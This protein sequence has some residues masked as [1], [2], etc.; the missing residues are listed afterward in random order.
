MKHIVLITSGQPTTNPR[1]VKEADALSA[2][3]YRV[4]VLHCY[5]N[6]WAT[7]ADVEMMENKPWKRMCI[8]GD[9]R[10]RKVAYFTSKLCFWA[11]KKLSQRSFKLPISQYALSR[12]T[13]PL[14]RA[15]KRMPADLYIAHNLA[16]LPAAIAAAKEHQAMAGFDAEDYHRHETNSSRF[17]WEYKL[18]VMLEDQYVPKLDYIST[19]SKAIAA[20]YQV[21]YQRSPMVIR[22]V[23]PAVKQCHKNLIHLAAA[24]IKLFWFSQTIGPNRGLELVIE[25]LRYLQSAK[26]ELHLLGEPK[27]GYISKLVDHA[28]KN[29]L[30]VNKL[31]FHR[32]LPADQLSEFCGTF[33][34][35]LAPE[36]AYC[37]NNDL[38]LSNKLFTYI[39]T[40]LAV[41]LSDTS[42][43]TA[44]YN[45]HPQIGK[46][47]Q[48]DDA[49]DLARWIQFYIDHPEELM[50]TKV[51]NYNLGQRSLNWETEGK[52]F[53]N[54]IKLTLHE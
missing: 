27:T 17:S 11:A 23:F 9:P 35:G 3:G 40:G 37:Q 2:V 49:R 1:L 29:G 22:N 28:L 33:D 48:K 7:I 31:H 30:Q 32:P 34:V 20:R 25:S 4:T 10:K 43:Q 36:P 16:A 51:S 42:A 12:A 26:F 41:L 5:W 44:F 46:C 14:V 39:Q 21:H 50:H 47:Y 38:A 54:K 13:L 19:S 18:K 8:G 6:S 24:P 53:L 45:E 15:A 52:L